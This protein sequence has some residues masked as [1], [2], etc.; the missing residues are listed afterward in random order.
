MKKVLFLA[1]KDLRVL[2]SNKS[3]FFWVLGFPVIFALFFGAIYSGAG[4]GPTGMKI[5]IVNEDKS[6]FQTTIFQGW[7]PMKH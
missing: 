6:E 3:N 7:S 2:I 4:E 5:A 1:L